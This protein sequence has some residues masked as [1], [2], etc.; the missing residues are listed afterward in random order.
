M[1]TRHWHLTYPRDLLAEPV[2]WQLGHEHDVVVN[3]RRA[4]VRDDVGWVI[5][6]AAG[7]EPALASA[8]EWLTATG[9]RVE[10]LPADAG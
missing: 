9:V 6:E 7:D 1:P 2:L 5:V 10:E 4:D 8:V 3:V